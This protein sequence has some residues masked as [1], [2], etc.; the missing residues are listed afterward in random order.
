MKVIKFIGFRVQ[1]LFTRNQAA[2]P[3][4]PKDDL[5]W[6]VEPYMCSQASHKED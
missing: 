4:K 5:N 6:T 3:T 1:A 2:P